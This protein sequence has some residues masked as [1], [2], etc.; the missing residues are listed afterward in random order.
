MF[1]GGPTLDAA[2]EPYRAAP[3]LQTCIELPGTAGRGEL[4]L[5][6]EALEDPARRFA[7]LA[8]PGVYHGA[9]ALED[10]RSA[11]TEDASC[12]DGFHSLRDVWSRPA[13]VATGVAS[14]LAQAR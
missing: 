12:V 2:F 9:L 10:Y 3:E 11:K 13:F 6:K 1:V 7:W 4:H 8:Q 14:R 5:Q